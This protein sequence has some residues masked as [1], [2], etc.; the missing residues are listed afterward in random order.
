[1]LQNFLFWLIFN[2]FLQKDITKAAKF[3]S[4]RFDDLDLCF[5][6]LQT[7]EEDVSTADIAADKEH[8]NTEEKE[9]DENENGKT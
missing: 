7:R 8:N 3:I 5:K 4:E 2:F 6:E 9:L 1:M